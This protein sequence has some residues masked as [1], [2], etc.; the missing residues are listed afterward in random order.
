MKKAAWFTVLGVLGFLYI[1]S[2]IPDLRVLPVLRQILEFTRGFD[3]IFERLAAFIAARL[4]AAGGSS[5]F[6]PIDS[7]MQDFLVYM[8]RNPVLIEFFL[9]KI[10]HIMVFFTLT[11][12]LFFLLYQYI[13]SKSLTLFLTFAGGFIFSVLDEIRQYYVPGRVGS[14]FDVMVNMIGVSLGIVVIIFALI[15][16]SG[17]RYRYFR[18]EGIR[19]KLK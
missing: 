19:K 10:V 7:V 4:P 5:Y 17:E 1:A 3:V 9:R 8:R 11:L 14:P 12:T 6:A 13:A 16:T 18:S 2:S 15:I